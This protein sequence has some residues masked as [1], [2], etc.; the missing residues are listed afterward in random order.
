VTIKNLAFNPAALSVPH[1]TT[2]TWTN[3]DSIAHTSTSDAGG[4]WDSG[5]IAPNGGAFS[6]TFNFAPGTYTYHCSIH[7]FMHGSITVT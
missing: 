5:I 6:F 2:V 1:G 3:K 7:A 4:Q